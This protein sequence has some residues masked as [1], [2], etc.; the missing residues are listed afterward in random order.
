MSLKEI[1]YQNV[2]RFINESLLDCKKIQALFSEL[3]QLDHSLLWHA[4]KEG[5]M[6]SLNFYNFSEQLV[7]DYEEIHSTNDVMHPKK[8]LAKLGSSKETV[9]RIGEVATVKELSR[10]SYNR[11]IERH[12]IVDQMVMYLSTATTVFAGIGFVRF[13]GEGVFT[14]NDKEVLQAL[15]IHLQ[16][17]VINSMHIREVAT[18]NLLTNSNTEPKITLSSREMQVYQLLIKGYSN[19]EIADLLFITINTVKKHLRNMYVKYQV[20]SRTSL[21]Y[22]LNSSAL[23]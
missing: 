16:H 14:Q 6:H 9:Y 18:V 3:F 19:I 11:F 20:N 15:S 4:D 23:R 8:H 1:D 7:W 17:L 13:K 21:L 10:S 5:N 12:E 2:V 22:K